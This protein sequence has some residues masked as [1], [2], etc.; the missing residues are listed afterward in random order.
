MDALP[1]QGRNN[2]GSRLQLDNTE[3]I[4]TKPLIIVL[5]QMKSRIL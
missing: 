5:M 1:I 2:I 3:E 4:D